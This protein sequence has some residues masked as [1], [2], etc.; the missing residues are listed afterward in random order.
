MACHFAA[1]SEIAGGPNTVAYRPGSVGRTAGR[2]GCVV[3]DRLVGLLIHDHSLLY[4]C[5]IYS[6]IAPILTRTAASTAPFYT[7]P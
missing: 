1:G 2:G 4:G 6:L 3:E 5:C 7:E